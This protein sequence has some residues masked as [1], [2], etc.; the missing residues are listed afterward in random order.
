MD[1]ACKSC[2]SNNQ[3]KFN[4]EIAIHWREFQNIDKALV[5]VFPQL[6]VCSDCGIA[7][8]AVPEAQLFQL[9]FH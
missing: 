1:M 6:V 9:S 5:W 2:G 4:G 8:F 3:R 7:E